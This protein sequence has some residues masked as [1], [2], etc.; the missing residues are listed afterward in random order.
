[1][2]DETQ[3]QKMRLDL[4]GAYVRAIRVRAGL[5]DVDPRDVV[6]AALDGYL[7]AELELV[8]RR[9]AETDVPGGSPPASPRG[10]RR[11]GK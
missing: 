8:R 7:A 1:M 9:R 11:K 3:R 5:D 10:R 4:P 2:T 6:T